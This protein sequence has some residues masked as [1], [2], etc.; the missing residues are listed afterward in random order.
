MKIK[1]IITIFE[2]VKE[3]KML[4]DIVQIYD[5]KILLKISNKISENT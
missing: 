3:I 2:L 1:K 4:D 5:L